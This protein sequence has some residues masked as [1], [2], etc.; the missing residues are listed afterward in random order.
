MVLWYTVHYSHA[1]QYYAVL[2]LTCSIFIPCS[3]EEEDD[4]FSS[5][6][7]GIF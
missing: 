2:D 3:N 6:F 4:V 5:V 7:A 1:T